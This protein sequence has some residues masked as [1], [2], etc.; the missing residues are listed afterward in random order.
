MYGFEV[1]DIDGSDITEDTNFFEA[2][3]DSVTA[4]R[5]AHAMSVSVAIEDRLQINPTQGELAESC[6]EAGRL[7]KPKDTASDV[8]IL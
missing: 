4:L 8:S 2:G 1:L 7:S 6:K 5:L 3:G